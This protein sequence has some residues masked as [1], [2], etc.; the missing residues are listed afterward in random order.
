MRF[1]ISLL[2]AVFVFHTAQADPARDPVFVDFYFS[3]ADLDHEPGAQGVLYRIVETVGEVCR[4]Q[5][6]ES[7]IKRQID[8]DCLN[9]MVAN[10]VTQIDDPKL[11]AMYHQWSGQHT[12]SATLD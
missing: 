5:R 4:E 1:V 6:A 8:P 10:A 7:R 2:L 9:E 11:T 12:R 3:R